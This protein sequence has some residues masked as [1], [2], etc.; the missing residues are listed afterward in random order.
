MDARY[1]ALRRAVEATPAVDA[2]AHNLVAPD[3]AFPFDRCFSEAEGDVLAHAPHSLSFKVGHTQQALHMLRSVRDIAALYNCQASLE[4]VE[5]CR[6]AEGFTSISSKCFR[7]ANISAIL[8]DDDMSFDKMLDMESHKAVAPVVVRILGIECLAE[9]VL[10]DESFSGLIWTLE[11]LTEAYIAKLKSYPPDFSITSGLDINPNVSKKDAEDGLRKE[12]ADVDQDLGKCNPL[13][14]RAVLDDERF[15][16]SQLVLLHASYPFSKE[17]SYL[18]SV[19]SQV[20]FST[21]GYAFPDTYYLGARRARDIVYRVLAAACEDGDLTIK[22]AIEAVEDIFRGNALHLYKFNAATGSTNHEPARAG[23]N[24]SSSSVEDVLFVRIVWIDASGQ[25]RCRVVPARR[26]YETTMD[27]GVGLPL[28]IMGL[29]SFS[30]HPAEGTNF[31]G[32]GEM[33]LVP[34]MSTIC[35]LPWY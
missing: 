29:T 11:S 13:H 27:Q 22:E 26:F 3:S 5:E 18:A 34:D 19:Y 35:R 17:A 25:I 7:A 20:M 24:M 15:A 8:I 2:H 14:L 4:K 10:N 9:T 30:D 6:R 28:A 1:A 32:V 23:D 12:L 33:R 21:D 16:K 31:T